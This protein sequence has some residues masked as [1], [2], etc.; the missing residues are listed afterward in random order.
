MKALDSLPPTLDKT[1]EK[2]L[3]RLDATED[4][5]LARNILELLAFTLRPLLLSE[6]WEAL[7]ITPGLPHLDESK[8]LTNPIE[9]LD[10][11]G[12][13]V[14][15]D[16]ETGR[17]ALSHHSVQTYLTSNPQNEAAVFKLDAQQS[18]STVAQLCLAY[19]SLDHFKDKD[20]D[21]PSLLY[22]KYP[23]LHYAAFHWAKHMQH[24]SQPT[25]PLLHELKTFLFSADCG[26]HNFT[27]WV[28][29]LIPRSKFADGTKPLYYAA[30]YGLLPVVKLLLNLGVD[31][32]AP[33][34]RMGATAI[35]IA[36]FRGHLE[37]VEV[38]WEAGADP[39]REDADRT[40]AIQWAYINGDKR[41]LEYFERV[42]YRQRISR[43]RDG[44]DSF[45]LQPNYFLDES[46][47]KPRGKMGGLADAAD[48]ISHESKN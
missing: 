20:I 46:V 43:I 14:Q 39:L 42:G 24:I 21:R 32:E 10:I 30:S 37:V 12:S 27:N 31:I 19:L 22:R 13:L 9:V 33:G 11:C 16:E 38:L 41:V 3:C 34:G 8:R 44:P 40:N 29:T 6:I 47:A 7:Q 25:D 18:H 26:R 5:A 17:V 15:Y 4:R 2:L 35:G 36:A 45:V 28:R 1:Y 48:Q 23:F